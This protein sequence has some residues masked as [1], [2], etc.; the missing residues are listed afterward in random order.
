MTGTA[1]DALRRDGLVVLPG[2]RAQM[3]EDVA[4]FLAAKPVFDGHVKY[5]NGGR[6]ATPSSTQTCWQMA[7]VLQAPHVLEYALALTDIVAE[8]LGVDPPLMY[9]MN[10]FTMRPGHGPTSLDTQEFHR[11]KDDSRFVALFV[12]LTDVPVAAAGAHQFQLSTHDGSESG[13]VAEVTGPAGTSFLSDGRG[14]HRG[15]R[16]AASPRSILWVRWGV[17]DPPAAYQW[18]HLRP[19]DRAILGDGY[20]SDYRLQRSIRLVAA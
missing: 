8:Y 19:S 7:D 17:S 3:V 2:M 1:V 10:A 12:Y 5:G 9:S 16:P 20:P 4:D 14:L 13:L 18:C 6:A 11:D 15:L